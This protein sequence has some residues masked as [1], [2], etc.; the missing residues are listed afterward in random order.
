MA[1]FVATLALVELES[2]SRGR[3]FWDRD[4]NHCVVLAPQAEDISTHLDPKSDTYTSLPP[5]MAESHTLTI[6]NHVNLASR[7]TVTEADAFMKPF[8]LSMNAEKSVIEDG[9]SAQI[10]YFH[11]ATRRWYRANATLAEINEDPT[12]NWLQALTD[13]FPWA[14]L[15]QEGEEDRVVVLPQWDRSAE[16]EFVVVNGES[17]SKVEGFGLTQVWGAGEGVQAPSGGSVKE[18]AEVWFDRLD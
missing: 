17:G 15:E 2:G 13:L 4:F 12:R 1:I 8:N 9:K 11:R 18:R 6:Y 3:L 14:I 7:P 10:R 5:T 16:L